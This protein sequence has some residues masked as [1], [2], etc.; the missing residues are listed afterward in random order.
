MFVPAVAV[1]A[2]GVPVKAGLA[3]GA[4]P[5]AL[6]NEAADK[7]V[8]ELSALNLGNVTALGLARVNILAPIVVAPKLV[9]AP[10]AVVD[11]VPP[12]ATATV[13][14]TFAAVPDMLPEGTT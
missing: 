8:I 11:P 5:I 13:P 14:D 10:E 4:P 12:L 3:K 2:V 9:R 7:E 1:G 6:K